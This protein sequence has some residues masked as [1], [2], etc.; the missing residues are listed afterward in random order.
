MPD[1]ITSPKILSVSELNSRIRRLLEINFTHIRIEGELSSLAR[2]RSGHWY[3]TLKDDQAQ[4]RCAMF[5]GRNQHI[6]FIPAEG[7]QVR[8]RANA[9]LY[10]GRGD[11]QLI[12]EHMEETGA[13][14]LQKAFEKLKKKL[15]SEGLF[16]TERKRPIP[17]IPQH[18]GIITS[19]TGAAIR[20][21]LTV[22][23]RR[24]PAIPITI[25]PSMVQG[26]EAAK[27]LYRTLEQAKRYHQ[28]NPIDVLV[29]TR[30][31]GSM[32]DLRPFNDEK[33]ARS[34]ADSPIPVV[35]AIGHEVDFTIADFVA[36]LRAPTPSAAAELI[37]PDYREWLQQ[38][39]TCQQH[40]TTHMTYRLNLLQHRLATV[41]GQL[42]RPDDRLREVSQRLDD[43]DIR[44]TQAIKMQ[45]KHQNTR[46][47]YV[48]N[49]L[50]QTNPAH[51]IQQWHIRLGILSRQLPSLIKG[52]LKNHWLLLSNLGN[53]LQAVSPLST[54]SR[55]YSI[56]Q[57]ESIVIINSQQ[58]QPGDQ[59]SAQ[60]HK[61]SAQCRVESV[62]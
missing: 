18:I 6:S 60:F 16:D 29:I 5:R 12:V 44:L 38:I 20:D 31:G 24:F 21:I 28:K 53:Q 62:S 30:G 42:R 9:S 3:F 36:D 32:E 52:Q 23:K 26:D 22:L 37:S 54:L 15:A 59:I 10:E 1:D 61:G 11:Y 39:N 58:L 25:I 34:I 56:V 19:P 7:M 40:L 50:I 51:L 47:Q 55:G 48:R 17:A 2:P 46:F 49:Q 57:K 13:G 43:L 14:D 33:L 8:V 41:S 45:L 4:V 27:H 35:S